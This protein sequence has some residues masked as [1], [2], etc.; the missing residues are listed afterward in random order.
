MLEA[1]VHFPT[2]L[3]LLWDSARKCIDICQW[4][5]KNY[6]YHGWRKSAMWRKE[7]KTIFRVS[8]RVNRSRI[9]HEHKQQVTT[10][11]LNWCRKLEKKVVS[12]I[13]RINSGHSI[14]MLSKLLELEYYL[15]MLRKHIDLVERRILRGEVISPDEKLYSIFEMHTEWITKGKSH[16]PVELG[17]NMLIASDQFHFIVHHQI[18]ERSSDSL[19]SVD[20]ADQ[21]ARKFPDRIHSLSLDKGFYSKD[22]K[23]KLSK[24]IPMPVMPKR[25]KRSKEE[26]E[27]EHS[28]EFRKLR[29][30]HSAVES[31]INQLEHNGLNRCPD[32]GMKNFKR[33]AAL[34]VLAYNIHWLG[35]YCVADQVENL[36]KKAA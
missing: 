4:I 14:E 16:K 27:I 31:N 25:G 1:N 34:S 28:K 29:Y 7:I 15:E 6:A 11:Y 23:E 26:T 22:N 35:K 19:L 12:F 17:H 36:S 8:S 3:N 9:K 33:Y 10:N 24:I 30:A 18:I 20:L 5:S 21:L 13:E 2:D 32:K